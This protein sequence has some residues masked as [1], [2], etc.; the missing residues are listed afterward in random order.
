MIK[1]L[2]K[3]FNFIVFCSKYNY[4]SREK[5]YNGVE[6]VFI[7]FKANGYQ[8]VLYDI[9]SI[10]YSIYKSDILLVLGISGSIILPLIKLISK[11]KIIMSVDGLDPKREKWSWI[12]K[13]FLEL[14]EWCAVKYSDAVISDNNE[15]K[16]YIDEKYN[17]NSHLIV[18]GADHSTKINPID[19]DLKRFPFLNKDYAIAIARI[20]KE[21]HSEVI[22]KAFSNDSDI[23]LVFVGT[24]KGN[25]YSKELFRQYKSVK[26]IILID[27]IYN[28]Y[29]INLLRSNAIIFIHGNSAG[30][31]NP[32][33]LEAMQV[34]LPIIAF[35][36][37]F[38]R[39]VTQE[40]ALFFRDDIQLS[41]KVKDYLMN[42]DLRNE[43]KEA[44]ERVARKEFGWDKI[45]EAYKELF[46]SY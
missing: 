46:N 21:N 34:G 11:K 3:D 25:D 31:T 13:K 33:L 27:P 17:K 45:A 23:K 29:Y 8:S 6:R 10:V 28:H 19:K 44:V 12:V 42:D 5:E 43:Y 38:N 35:D 37:V 20:E 24:W 30:G 39:N 2:S 1:H 15:I 40:K 7:P 9:I 32:G 41:A 16:K 4:K 22:L 36:V 14:S 18:Y 26:N